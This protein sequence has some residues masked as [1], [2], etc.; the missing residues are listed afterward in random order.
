MSNTEFVMV[1]RELCEEIANPRNGFALADA[2]EALCNLLAKPAEQHQVKPVKWW[3]GCNTEVPA[4]LRFL[5]NNERPYHGESRFNAAHLYQLAAEIERMAA[6]KLYSHP[7]Q[8]E[9]GEPVA[10][11]ER[12]TVAA[13]LLSES[14]THNRGWNACLDET[15]KLGPLYSHADPDEVAR[16]RAE[17]VEWKERCQSNS[18]EA[19]SWMAKHD[20]LRAKMAERDALLARVVNS[21]AL[22]SEQ[23]EELEADCCSAVDVVHQI[24]RQAFREH[25]DKCA[26]L[27][28]S[29]EPSAPI[30]TLTAAEMLKVQKPKVDQK[31]KLA[32][33]ESMQAF[34]DA[35]AIAMS[36]SSTRF[37]FFC[38][39]EVIDL[40]VPE[41][42]SLGF[43]VERGNGSNAGTVL[44]I[45]CNGVDNHE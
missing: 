45:E 33:E 30:K 14:N 17:I 43:S 26:T 25:L 6:M 24:K 18:D 40:V 29:A 23:H 12:K 11:P 22:S 20:T 13:G 32:F 19:M 34:R 10:L 31:I 27:S 8:D 21:G 3:N 35:M 16:L 2:R 4:A 44:Y 15:A 1:P 41:I 36:G 7:A 5:A 37:S 39:Y 42:K 28:V 38:D 9:R